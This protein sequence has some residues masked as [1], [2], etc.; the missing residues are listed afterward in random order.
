VV[1]TPCVN[2][3]EV[4]AHSIA[5]ELDI[6]VRRALPYNAQSKVVERFFREM[7]EGDAFFRGY[8]GNTPYNRP[9]SA[10]VW[11]KPENCDRLMSVQQA[12]G[13]I[14]DF[15]RAY[16]LK[17]SN[18]KY[19]KG[20]SPAQA[21]TPELRLK[22]PNMTPQE[23]FLAFLKPLARSRV[24][25]PRGPSVVCG[26]FRYAAVDRKAL[27]PYDG[28]PVMVKF[29][30]IDANR[31][32]A[33]SLDGKFLTECRRPEYVPYFARTPEERAKLS[34]ALERREGERKELRALIMAETKGFHRLDPASIYLL[35]AETIETGA[36]LRLI[37]RRTSVKG[38][39]HNP[40]I[41]GLPGEAAPQLPQLPQPADRLQP[42]KPAPAFLPPPVSKE[43]KADPD[44]LR[45]LT[46]LLKRQ[47]PTR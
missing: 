3:S 16:H 34:D 14:D 6:E 41:Y 43:Q 19:C 37:D 9:A 23:Y 46:D 27:W 5:K 1:F 20:L 4:Y 36:R 39:T 42:A 17:P 7:M 25:D 12:A 15:I 10:E 2:G 29:D 35:D 24:V 44:K 32:F 38:E 28:K 26:K 8:V 47:A 30:N 21:F 13:A 22:R 45:K 18:G 11:A 40:A 31:C 33:F